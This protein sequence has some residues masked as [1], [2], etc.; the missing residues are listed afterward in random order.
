MILYSNCNIRALL[1]TVLKP[2][3]KIYKKHRI[4]NIRDSKHQIK[5]KAVNLIARLW[6]KLDKRDSPNQNHSKKWE[7]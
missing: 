3:Q 7:Q 4:I 5:P 2:C 6:I 1:E